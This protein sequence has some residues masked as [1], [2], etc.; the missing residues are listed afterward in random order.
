MLPFM[1][2]ALLSVACLIQRRGCHRPTDVNTRLRMSVSASMKEGPSPAGMAP[3]ALRPSGRVVLRS[4]YAL[5]CGPSPTTGAMCPSRC[6]TPSTRA[7]IVSSRA[8]LSSLAFR[9]SGASPTYA[10]SVKTA[11]STSSPYSS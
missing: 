10:L 4:V 2:L 9:E 5:R 6:S 7:N 11:S 1:P 8:A 3:R